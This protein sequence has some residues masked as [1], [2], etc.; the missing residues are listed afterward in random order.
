MIIVDDGQLERARLQLRAM[1]SSFLYNPDYD[2]NLIDFGFPRRTNPA[3]GARYWDT[4]SAALRFHVTLKYTL[5]QLER[6]EKKVLPRQIGPFQTDVIEAEYGVTLPVDAPAGPRASPRE[7]LCGGLGISAFSGVYGTLGGI[8]RERRTG[9]LMIMSNW[10]VLYF[11]QNTAPGQPIYQPIM[12]AGRPQPALVA[13]VAAERISAPHSGQLPLDV[14][15]APLVDQG[16]GRWE[17]HQLEVGPVTGVARAR[18]GMQVVKSG[19][20][21][22]RTFGAVSGVEGFSKMNYAGG[23]RRLIERVVTIS[24]WP[25][26]RGPGPV[27]QGGDSGC[28]WLEAASGR[29]VA[30]HYAGLRDG[31]RAQAMDMQHVLDEMGVEIA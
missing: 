29:A 24:R 8:V 11:T 7:R 20:T 4:E 17:N 26:D 25:L 5:E 3:T 30:L 6:L 12:L 1:V 2:I 19:L 28:W 18:L 10:H 23:Y 21:T 16:D 13:R 31:T 22:G 9:R 15:V 14:A 27:S